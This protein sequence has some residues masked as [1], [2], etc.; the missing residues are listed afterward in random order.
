MTS[1]RC[2]ALIAGLVLIAS[3]P[4]QKGRR[5][6]KSL[7]DVVPPPPKVFL[8]DA[9]ALTAESAILID[10]ISGKVLW[11]KNADVPRFPAS[12]T[13][14]MTA[15]LLIER[16]APEEVVI[17]PADI[18]KTGEASLHLKP[19][20][21]LTVR[22]LLWGI[23]L[24]SG[25]DGCVAAAVHC[26]GSV[27]KFADIMNARARQL[28]CTNTNF[29]NPNGLKDP[30]HV[31]SA[32]DLALIA[33]E[34][35][36][37]PEFREIV[38]T[39]RHEITRS[40]NQADRFMI[41]KN[42]LLDADKTMDG[43][44]TGFT[45]PAGQCF[46]G[47]ATRG[48]NR[49]ITVVLKST[50]WVQDTQSLLNWGFNQFEVRRPITAG[51]SVAK[52]IVGATEV[53]AGPVRAVRNVAAKGSPDDLHTEAIMV[54]SLRAPVVRGQQVGTLKVSDS[55]G[56]TDEIPLVALSSVA[57]SSPSASSKVPMVLGGAGLVGL[58]AGIRRRRNRMY[59]KI[60]SS[61]RFL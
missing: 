56:W 4:A 24:R 18:E 23:L 55:T 44:K 12:T 45:I 17:A 15:L 57:A 52:V 13:K 46:V 28:G 20:E 58:W 19:G 34:A 21:T 39:R 30:N 33:R 26:A 7:E 5:Q 32:H 9:K 41:S 47:S 36:R 54:K 42:K 6:A 22:D 53:E 51:Q 8:P 31:V 2:F 37:Y 16:C 59:G 61:N 14:I 60:L 40:I 50:T 49:F 35:M 27:E 3:V 11:S 1:S 29:R 43:I 38:K 48:G 25:N 10:E